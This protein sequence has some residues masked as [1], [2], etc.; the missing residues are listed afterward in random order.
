MRQNL[1]TWLPILLLVVLGALAGLGEILQSGFDSSSD[2]PK[3]L[4]VSSQSDRGPGSLREALFT[5]MKAPHRVTIRIDV[6]RIDI[7]V[8]LPPIAA[9]GITIIGNSVSPPLL[10]RI[11]K[12]ASNVAMLQIVANDVRVSDIDVDA[13]KAIA[14]SIGGERSI[15]ERVSVKNASV[16][17]D[18][19][20]I[21]DLVV[22]S[23]EF[24]ENDLGL[25][26]TGTVSTAT[27][28]N[29]TFRDN[30]Q[31]GVWI[32][33]ASD[34]PDSDSDIRV[35]DNS[36]FGGRDALVSVNVS[37]DIRSNRIS[38]FS[39]TGMTLQDARAM[40]AGNRI[41][42]SNG[43][44]IH[45]SRLRNSTVVDNEIA[46]NKQ[47]GILI[48]DAN[49]LQVDRNQVYENGYGIA[50][51]G[52]Q[53]INASVRQNTVVSQ[54]IDGLIAIGESPLIDGNHS[55]KNGQAGIRILNLVRAGE[56]TI[57]ALPR[58]ANNTL[59]GNGEDTVQFGDYVVRAE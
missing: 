40:V 26:L 23:S 2:I 42:D 25:R 3:E 38:R 9:N 57:T 35:H 6:E 36:F 18:G 28:T 51:V 8:P 34:D 53:P 55:L 58:L 10:Q 22:R 30:R 1:T 21:E 12:D 24:V 44:G 45:I 48:V 43:V 13:A 46:R 50:A 47:I 20:D 33:L 39:H 7:D 56:P 5:A 29:N 17:V 19:T 15:L 32:A 14:V 4:R 27:I 11:S 52:L 31:S 54:S 49:G 41:L 37:V 16:A 59:S